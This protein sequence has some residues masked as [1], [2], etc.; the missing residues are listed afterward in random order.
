MAEP[1]AAG[2]APLRHLT[3]TGFVVWREQTLLHWH[4]KNRLW[5]PFGGHIEA[6]E[7]PVQCVLREILE[8]SGVQAAMLDF[9]PPLPFA[10][11]PQLP[12]PVTILL[13]QVSDGVQQHEHIDLIYYCRPLHEPPLRF[14]DPTT[15]WVGR[16]ELE[17]NEP[18][19][20]A[21]GEAPACVPEDVRLLALDAIAR[22][23]RTE[24]D[25]ERHMQSP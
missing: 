18:V 24:H 5:L 1:A 17:R 11:P 8:E 15:R 20:P 12:P 13:E 21:P 14:D 10:Y 25:R 3:A 9:A 7:D 16:A 19:A 6:N 23:Q 4:R 22:V 2:A